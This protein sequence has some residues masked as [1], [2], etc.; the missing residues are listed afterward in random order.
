MKE[1]IEI[2][3]NIPAYEFED[4]YPEHLAQE[5]A[6]Q[7]K[8]SA[9]STT[10][11][12]LSKVSQIST[13]VS[14]GSKM[15]IK[16]DEIELTRSERRLEP[17]WNIRMKRII[18]YE[19]DK[20]YRVEVENADAQSII[21]DGSTDELKVNSP[22][23]MNI[24]TSYISFKA[25]EKCQRDIIFSGVIDGMERGYI[26]EELLQSYLKNDKYRRKTLTSEVVEP[27]LL[28]TGLLQRARKKLSETTEINAGKL[29][30]DTILEYLEI[31]FRPVFVFEYQHK[32]DNRIA[33]IEVD[34]LTGEVIDSGTSWF[35]QKAN[36]E[37]MKTLLTGVM[38]EVAGYLIPGGATITKT[39]ADIILDAKK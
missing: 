21:I 31:Y 35:S 7:R 16:D 23:N 30:E 3:D 34:G 26:Y 11:S 8:N 10:L 13:L 22:Q 12:T 4:Y 36:Q 17:F 28:T 37:K 5:A 19:L 2:Q 29:E 32:K 39:V 9:F 15:L 24:S 33:I 14:K 1:V 38:S 6:E 27:T 20:T 25:K 18:R